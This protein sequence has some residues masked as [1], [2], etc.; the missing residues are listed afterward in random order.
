MVC[1]SGGSGAGSTRMELGRLLD[2]WAEMM[3]EIAA[4]RPVLARGGLQG[5]G[6]ESLRAAERAVLAHEQRARVLQDRIVAL[7]AGQ[8]DEA[9]VLAQLL[10]RLGEANDWD[11]EALPPQV[12]RRLITVVAAEG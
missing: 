10:K 11:T 8:S 12:L 9:R 2:A 6:F 5:G 3:A 4:Q 7:A 1:A